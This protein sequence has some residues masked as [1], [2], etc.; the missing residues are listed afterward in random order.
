M[1][2]TLNGIGEVT[3]TPEELDHL[4]RLNGIKELLRLTGGDSSN[5]PAQSECRAHPGDN[6]GREPNSLIT[7]SVTIDTER[8][9]RKPTRSMG[10]IMLAYLRHGGAISLRQLLQDTGF[11][12]GGSL[13]KPNGALNERM[14]TASANRIH[15]FNTVH[16]ATSENGGSERVYKVSPEVLEFLRANEARIIALSNLAS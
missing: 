3:C 14:R 13:R 6:G 12:S 9:F 5:R 4:L 2:A 15:E 1:K 8:F 7:N 16:E 11:R 10:Q